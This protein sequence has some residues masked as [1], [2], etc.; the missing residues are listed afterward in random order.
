MVAEI[1]VDEAIRVLN[2]VVSCA[3]FPEGCISFDGP[4]SVTCLT[5]IWIKA[6]CS[7][8]GS[9]RPKSPVK[10]DRMLLS[11]FTIA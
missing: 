7:Q 11:S 8:D 10:E 3:E 4:H 5:N 2:C 6:G 1:F 9:L